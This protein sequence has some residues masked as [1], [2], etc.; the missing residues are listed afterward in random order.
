[1]SEQVSNPRQHTAAYVGLTLTAA[2]WAGNAVMARGVVDTIPPLA[3][4]FWRWVLALLLVL[5]FSL[6]ALRR[7][8][9]VLHR[10][11]RTM[12]P[13]AGLSV[14][15]FNTLLYLAA[16]TTTAVNIS[17]I[18]ATMPIVVALFAWGILGARTRA[19]QAVGI[20][21]A[22]VGMLVVVARGDPGVLLGLDFQP[23][24]LL[25]VAAVCS[26]GLFS[27]IM[28]KHPIPVSPQV[29]L[30]GQ[31]LFGI[32]VIL[33]FYLIELAL[34]GGF[35]MRPTLVLPFLY[36][37]VFPGLLAFTFWNYGVSRVG[38]SRSAMFIYL[39]PVFAAGLAWAILG[40]GLSGFH[41]VGG[42]LILIGL[43][44]ATQ[45]RVRD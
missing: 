8:W 12:L 2:F 6:P 15:V 5:P 4:S 44:L 43:Y 45:A 20:A 42:V 28:R 11:W 10:H 21:F 7:E 16:T 26:W 24:D 9:P 39:L 14:G 32:P 35:S 34:V 17:L 13:I 40:E 38:P 33:P 22:L 18:N 3:L 36:V 23:G 19:L 1:M 29:F 37:A 25:M 30:T 31:I 41:A 27:V